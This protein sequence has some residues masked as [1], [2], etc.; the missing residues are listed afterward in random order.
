MLQTK[1]EVVVCEMT[2]Y[3][4]FTFICSGGKKIYSVGLGRGEARMAKIVF[5]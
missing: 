3:V 1:T 5:H 2:R 4:R